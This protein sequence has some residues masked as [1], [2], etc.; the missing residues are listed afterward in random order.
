MMMFFWVLATCRLV[1]RHPEDV[2]SIFLRNVASTDESTRR[3]SP[4]EQHNQNR[5]FI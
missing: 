2:D 1:G 3:Q 4:E 5:M